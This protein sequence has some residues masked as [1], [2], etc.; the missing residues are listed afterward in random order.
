MGAALAPILP[1]WLGDLTSAEAAA[2]AD[3][4]RVE[5]VLPTVTA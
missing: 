2:T 4:T 3:P 5:L 1:T